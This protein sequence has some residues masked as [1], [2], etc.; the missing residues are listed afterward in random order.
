MIEK[1]KVHFLEEAAEFL[2][3]LDEKTRD[4]IIYNITKAQRTSDNELF[5]KLTGEI[6]EFRALFKRLTTGSLHF[7]IKLTKLIL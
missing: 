3:N 5:K 1:F 2:D 7:G 4:K 6:W